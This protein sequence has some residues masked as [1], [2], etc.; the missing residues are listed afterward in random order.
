[1]Y[2]ELNLSALMERCKLEEL[3]RCSALFSHITGGTVPRYPF[4]Q[5]A[6]IIMVLFFMSLATVG[7]PFK[8][9]AGFLCAFFRIPRELLKG[10]YICIYEYSELLYFDS[11]NNGFLQYSFVLNDLKQTLCMRKILFSSNI[12]VFRTEKLLIVPLEG[13]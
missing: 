1:M 6:N 12:R 11:Y 5:D 10:K 7:K 3:H 2:L 9:I 13:K 4:T 8:N